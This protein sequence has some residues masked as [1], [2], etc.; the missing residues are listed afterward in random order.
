[1][2][3]RIHDKWNETHYRIH[4]AQILLS[5]TGERI[6][7]I[8]LKDDLETIGMYRD[9]ISVLVQEGIDPVVKEAM[10]NL[11]ELWDELKRE[12]TD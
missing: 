12:K 1:M 2:D 3:Q 10:K 5:L 8:C 11:N 6:D 4:Q 9:R 7:E